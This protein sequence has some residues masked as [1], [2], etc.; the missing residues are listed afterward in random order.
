MS[1]DLGSI[2]WGFVWLAVLAFLLGVGVGLPWGLVWSSWARNRDGPMPWTE[3]K[4][5]WQAVGPGALWRPAPGPEQRTMAPGGVPGTPREGDVPVADLWHNA[6]PQLRTID[7]KTGVESVLPY[8][9]L[10]TRIGEP[11]APDV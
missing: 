2:Q 8:G 9:D 1:N 4:G 11:V 6:K 7:P 3:A 5:R 10:G